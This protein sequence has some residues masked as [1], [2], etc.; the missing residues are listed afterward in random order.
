MFGRPS[1]CLQR[2]LVSSIVLIS[3]GTATATPS[4]STHPAGTAARE[5]LP[6]SVAPFVVGS[7]PVSR[8][9][10]SKRLT[11]E[12]WLRPRLAA[13]ARYATEVAEP[14]SPL[15]HRYLS[16]A[17]YT[18]RFGA[19]DSAEAAVE[20]FFRRSGYSAV[21]ADPQRAYVRATAPVRRI[22]A[23]FETALD[24]FPDS[25]LAGAG[26]FRLFGNVAPL[27]LPRRI[28]RRLLGVTGTDNASVLVPI[29]G[30]R[31][32][33]ARAS[34]TE[35][36]TS[37]KG[38]ASCSRYYGERLASG[39][40]KEFGRTSF[41]TIICG[42]TGRQ[43]REGY[44]A[45]SDASGKGVTVA[46]VEE[47][48]TKDMFLTLEDYA[49]RNGVPAPS[50]QRYEELSLGSDSCGDPFDGEEQ[51][52]VE[53]SYDMAPGANQLVVG[54]DS[55]NNGDYGNQSVFDADEAV[56]DGA[57]GHPLATIASNSWETGPESEPSSVIAIAHSYLLRA[58]AE[59]VGMY[60]SS[61]DGSGVLS[62]ASDPDAI[63]VG[64]T[65]LGIGKTG[66]RLF[67]TGWSDGQSVVRDGR[68]RLVEEEGA[69]GGG[70]SVIYG[71]PTYQV[72]VVP[73]SYGDHR[74]D[75]DISAD[76]DPFTGMALGQLSFKSGSHR[77]Y[78][79]PIGGTSESAPLVAGMVASAQEGEATAFGF[80]NP[81]I[82]SLAGTP[83]FFDS[84]PLTSASPSSYRAVEC[85]RVIFAELCGKP[86]VPT[87]M[88]FDDQSPSM[89]GY[90]GQVTA[91]GYDDMTGLG[92][93]D[94]PKF[95]TAL[96]E[97]DHDGRV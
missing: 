69:A 92:T 31:T 64:G 1:S 4:S 6:G 61:G 93:P 71:E 80:V 55:C 7:R 70:P 32:G 9:A 37:S 63:A 5:T 96:R 10:G 20:S 19:S 17:Q 97:L 27:S 36:A 25:H 22:E 49:A 62:P 53:A 40:P 13:A 52:D 45:S 75:P 30:L 57:N 33:V 23:T 47:G 76:A 43:L 46:L 58:A 90:T 3:I 38:L 26:P 83:A 11:I 78:Q 15:F 16:P 59:G 94:L 89:A 77:Y 50:P 88:T 79:I 87:L 67:E 29:R 24:Y 56:L 39:L 21:H 2:A 74:I 44:G 28:A 60:F 34:R 12:L 41:P 18:R 68:W 91:A 14:G 48:L 35:R 51:L 72:G 84:L 86:A 65:T 82:Y 54:G 42:Y 66:D 81:A 73:K 85:D 8:V 95:I